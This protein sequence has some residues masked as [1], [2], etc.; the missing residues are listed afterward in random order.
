MITFTFVALW[1]DVNRSLFTWGWLFGLFFLPEIAV[2]RWCAPYRSSRYFRYLLGLGAAYN[3]FV[4]MVANLIGYSMGT[5]G[6][7]VMLRQLFTTWD[8]LKL[9]AGA[10]GLLFIGAQVMFGVRD[11]ESRARRCSDQE[12]GWGGGA[13][14]GGSLADDGKRRA[15]AAAAS[16][17]PSLA[18]PRSP[19]RLKIS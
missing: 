7:L 15:A 3:I 2:S 13:S 10:Y 16:R 5:E 19:A 9:V 6:V 1:H 8:G 11:C 4:L 18:V 12:A 14:V 17:G